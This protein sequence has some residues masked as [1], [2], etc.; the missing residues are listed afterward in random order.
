MRPIK[1]TT[2]LAGARDTAVSRGT[3]GVL[4]LVDEVLFLA[5]I[6]RGRSVA[7][8]SS[9]SATDLANRRRRD[10]GLPRNF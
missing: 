7:P 5:A 6:F 1:E 4:L 9:E 2:A 10:C 8:P 3:A